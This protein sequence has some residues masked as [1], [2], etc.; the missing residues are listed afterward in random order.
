L[1]RHHGGFTEA[2]GRVVAVGQGSPAEAAGFARA[3]E[4]PY[5]V[6][7]DPARRGYAAYGLVEGG[8]GAFLNAATGMGVARALL[9]GS[10]GGRVVGNARQLPGAFV[11]DRAGI[12]RFAT[13]A[14]H[15]ADTPSAAALLGEL[16]EVL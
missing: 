15:A 14:R 2:G 3:L 12:V 4:L 10:R 7:A 11:I 6:L 8:A 13:A 5:P 9:R 1:R 16:A